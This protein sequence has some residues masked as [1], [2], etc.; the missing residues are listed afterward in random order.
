MPRQRSVSNIDKNHSEVPK[1]L[2][3]RCGGYWRDKENGHHYASYQGLKIC[4]YD[5]HKVGNGFPDWEVWISWLCLQIE[6]KQERKV[7]V[8]PKQGGGRAQKLSDEEY[9][10][11]Q[12][13]DTEL[14]YRRSH[15]S[16]VPI[17]HERNEVYEWIK[18]A[19]EFVFYCESKSEGSQALIN[20][21]FPRVTESF[22]H[23]ANAE[24]VQ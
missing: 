2:K 18:C 3:D 8:A 13:E 9:Y 4:A 15:S 16:I 12:L 19:A 22:Q 6:V 21:F 24:E 23:N 14:T 1:A 5:L 17:V 20:L 7:Y 11:H 10:Y